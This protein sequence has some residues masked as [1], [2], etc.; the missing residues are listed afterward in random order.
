MITTQERI[1]ADV[2]SVLPSAAVLKILADR[3]GTNANIASGEYEILL[4]K[5]I[6]EIKATCKNR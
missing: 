6:K 2:Q 1:A 3:W 4:N 5:N